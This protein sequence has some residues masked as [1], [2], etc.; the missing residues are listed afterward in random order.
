MLGIDYDTSADL[1]S[2]ACMVFE[3]ITGDFLFEPKKSQNYGKTDDHLAQMMEIL[4][5]MP[6][7]FAIAGKNFDNFFQ[8][9]EMSHKYNF[10]RIR[11]LRHFPLKK[12]LID[13]Y[14][15][16][17]EEADMLADFLMQ[18]LHWYPSDRASAQEMLNHP[19]LKMK[20]EYNYRMNDLEYK[21][22]NL[23]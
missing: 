21:K 5:P 14:R 4:G 10:K 6:K 18:M 8:K 2:F 13:K 20:D 22:Y 12:L 15:L 19:W 3:L 17:I 23:K 7:N 1:W 11:G 16:K 9:D